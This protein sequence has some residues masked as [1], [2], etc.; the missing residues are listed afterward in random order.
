MYFLKN[1]EDF[2]EIPSILREPVFEKAF[3]EAEYYRLSPLLQ[4]QYQRDLMA[5]RD[6]VNVVETA[7]KEGEAKGKAEGLAEG[8]AKG[9]AKGEAK[10]AAETA[11]KMKADG[12]E[13]SLIAKYTGLP[14]SEI[15]RL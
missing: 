1:L 3:S 2:D 10:K 12:V 13:V 7:R 6:N 5:Y 15:E 11:R 14:A 9:L 8:E 4:E